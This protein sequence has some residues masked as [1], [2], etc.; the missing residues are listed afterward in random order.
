MGTGPVANPRPLDPCLRSPDPR[1]PP[2]SAAALS[3]PSPPLACGLGDDSQLR[4]PVLFHARAGRLC[5]AAGGPPPPRRDGNRS[6][7]LARDMC[8]VC[9]GRRRIQL[10]KHADRPRRPRRLGAKGPAIWPLRP[11]LGCWKH[12]LA[13]DILTICSARRQVWHPPKPGRERA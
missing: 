2:S 13:G 4:S 12:R 7:R 9:S 1:P 10:P 11:S 8:T 6:Q 3:S 5:R